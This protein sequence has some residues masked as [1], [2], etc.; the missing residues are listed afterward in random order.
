MI[1]LSVVFQIYQPDHW[2]IVP[3]F[4]VTAATND[5]YKWNM[6]DAFYN[7]SNQ[8]RMFFK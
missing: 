8:A 1:S 5:E 7:V 4:N 6:N 3:G 2:C